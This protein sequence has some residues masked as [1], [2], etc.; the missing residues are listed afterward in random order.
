M[1]AV[2]VADL[3]DRPGG[4]GCFRYGGHLGEVASARLFDEHMLAASRQAV[5]ILESSAC[6]V[7]TTTTSISVASI[8]ARKSVA[9]RAPNGSANCTARCSCT[10]DGKNRPMAQSG[11][12]CGPLL[13]DK[14]TS[15]NCEPHVTHLGS[16]FGLAAEFGAV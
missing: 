1:E 8:A 13:P 11:D 10:I 14:A 9:E 15:D 7:A 16:G 2:V 3:C 6:G 5:A 4:I 12:S